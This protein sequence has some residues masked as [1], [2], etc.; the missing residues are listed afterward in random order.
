[1]ARFFPLTH[2]AVEV[3]FKLGI[4][5]QYP[6]EVVLTANLLGRYIIP[7]G[8]LKAAEIFPD[9]A[10]TDNETRGL[11]IIKALLEKSTTAI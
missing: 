3:R 11:L 5:T 9:Y 1:M 4:D 2:D 10:T 7:K 6:G 8:I